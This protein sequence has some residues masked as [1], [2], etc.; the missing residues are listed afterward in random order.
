LGEP[1]RAQKKQQHFKVL[2]LFLW[3]ASGY[4]L[5][6]LRAFRYAHALGGSAAIPLAKKQ[7]HK[8]M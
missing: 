2:L 4:P 8:I 3:L 5:H 6:H 1:L 7:L